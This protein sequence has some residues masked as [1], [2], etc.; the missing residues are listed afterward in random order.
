MGGR[1]GEEGGCCNCRGHKGEGEGEGGRGGGGGK[2]GRDVV[3]YNSLRFSNQKV[4][5]TELQWSLFCKTE[6][7]HT[8]TTAQTVLN[9][10]ATSHLFSA[11][12]LLIL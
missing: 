5:W 8:H 3:E 12:C 11:F 10:C 7:P 9:E 2:L 4:V 1:A 6:Q